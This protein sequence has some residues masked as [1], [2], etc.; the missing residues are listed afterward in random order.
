MALL[1]ISAHIFYLKD[2]AKTLV[3]T[4][5][6]GVKRDDSPDTSVVQE[7]PQ[8][9]NAAAMGTAHWGKDRDWW[10]WYDGGI[11]STAFALRALLA[12]DPKNALVEPVTN[13]LIQNR[14]GAQWTNTK[15]TAITVLTLNDYLKQSGE[16]KTDTEYELRVNGQAVATKRVT[17]AEVLSAPSRFTVDPALVQDGANTIEIRKKAGAGPL[18][19][20]AEAKFFSRE[21]PITPAGN[22][23][24][25]RRQYFK[26]V[27]HPTLLKGIVYENVPLNDGDSVQSGERVQCLITVEAKNDYEYLMFEDLKPAGLEAVELKSGEPLYAQQLKANAVG[28]KFGDGA[29]P[30][31]AATRPQS[32]DATDYTGQTQWVYQ[33]LRDRKAAFFL[34]K[35]PEGVWEIR[36]DLRAEVPGH[37][38]A[39]PVLGEAMYV[40]EIRANSSEIRMTVT[41]R[42]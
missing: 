32:A 3:D 5:V 24:F 4:L 1:A 38:H 6:N 21:E 35:L 10:H 9:S 29:K 20:A 25:V 31:T 30:G 41:D 2:L 22:G 26:R 27:G 28:V 36:Y 12:I 14:R 23:I 18:Y 37:F 19:F 42:E 34:D 13:W 40:P 15:D 8:T 7:G 33:E 16:L 17:P 39:L 11:E